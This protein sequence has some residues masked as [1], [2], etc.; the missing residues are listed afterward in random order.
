MVKSLLVIDCED[1]HLLNTKCCFGEA[2][3]TLP[4][5]WVLGRSHGVDSPRCYTLASFA[6]RWYNGLP[7]DNNI[8]VDTLEQRLATWFERYKMTMTLWDNYTDGVCDYWF[9]GAFSD[10]I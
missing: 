7:H 6:V 2:D 5:D 9:E 10:I 1:N 8:T 3:N 4:V